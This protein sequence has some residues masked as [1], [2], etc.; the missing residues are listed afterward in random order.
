MGE[1]SIKKNFTVRKGWVCGGHAIPAPVKE[2]LH[3][4]AEKYPYDSFV[5]DVSVA[6]DDSSKNYVFQTN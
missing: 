3:L 5:R 2:V 4:T 6:N 1:F